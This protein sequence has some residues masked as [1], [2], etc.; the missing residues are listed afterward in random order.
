MH[1]LVH[2]VW[3]KQREVDAVDDS[4]IMTTVMSII[5]AS[6]L[7]RHASNALLIAS[8]WKEFIS[9]DLPSKSSRPI[10]KRILANGT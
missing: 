6:L 3:L 10:S 2:C 1:V 4:H 7:R 5:G 9:A 8:S